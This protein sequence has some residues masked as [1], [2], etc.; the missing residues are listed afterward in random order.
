MGNIEYKPISRIDCSGGKAPH[1]NL[2]SSGASPR[3]FRFAVKNHNS[4]QIKKPWSVK[5]RCDGFLKQLFNGT[6]GVRN[7]NSERSRIIIEKLK[8]HP[9]LTLSGFHV[10]IWQRGFSA[11]AALTHPALASNHESRHSTAHARCAQSPQ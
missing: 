11:T 2:S 7:M 3:D 6:A 8:S 9:T 1:C 4:G 5:Q 10:L